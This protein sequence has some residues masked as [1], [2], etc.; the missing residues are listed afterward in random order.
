[1]ANGLWL[2]TVSSDPNSSI[3]QL[4]DEVK[5]GGPKQMAAE[6]KAVLELLP[7]AS[8]ADFFGTYNFLRWFGIITA[9]MPI[10][11]PKMD[12]TTKSDIAFAGRAGDGRMTVDV[13]LP[14]EHLMEI[15]SFF[16]KMQQQQ[17]QKMQQQQKPTI[18]ADQ[19]SA[20]KLRGIGKACLIYANDYD[21]KFPSNLQELVEKVELSPRT[22]E[23]PR[24]PK[25]F[26]GP[27][28]IYISGQNVTMDPGNIL[29]YENPAFC[30]DNINVLFV[31]SH[32]EAMKPDAF[33]KE[34]EATYKRLGREMPD[35]KFKDSSAPMK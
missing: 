4:I 11:L 1:M 2:C 35:I 31:D 18:G 29:V 12:I 27:S 33:L 3:R 20:M 23:S 6:V 30:S 22:L 32:V 16:Q 9:F 10:P 25:D 17:R 21:D 15:T 34:L 8:Q 13:A 24:K 28:Y 26:D 14:K 5:A 19:A 7:Q